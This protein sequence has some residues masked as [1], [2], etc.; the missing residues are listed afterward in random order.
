MLWMT[1]CVMQ[2]S[3]RP[4]SPFPP[5]V[6]QPRW[7]VAITCG[8]GSEK[9]VVR[10]AA[11]GEY[12]LVA[13]VDESSIGPK[14]RRLMA[15]GDTVVVLQTAQLDRS[16]GIVRHDGVM[17]GSW[18]CRCV[19]SYGQAGICPVYTN[20]TDCKPDIDCTLPEHAP[21]AHCKWTPN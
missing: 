14:T 9:A 6:E 19:G 4:D 8:S 13:A 12:A 5:G 11:T 1:L 16:F 10:S 7:Q 2:V 21:A 20:E 15:A 3:M 18:M 17:D